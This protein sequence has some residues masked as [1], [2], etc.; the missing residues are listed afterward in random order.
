MRASRRGRV[1][2]Y[3]PWTA[4]LLGLAPLLS[5]MPPGTPTAR[6]PFWRAVAFSSPG[7]LTAIVA[8]MMNT[9][10][11]RFYAARPGMTLGMVGAAF[12]LVRLID[13]P[14]DPVLG[15]LID[16]TRV[17]FGRYRLWLLASIPVLLVSFWALFLPPEKVGTGYLILW[18]L[19][20]NIGGSMVFLSHYPWAASLAPNY[21]ERSR[22]FAMIQVFNVIGSVGILLL[23]ALT[24]GRISAGD[25]ASTATIGIII[26][27]LVPLCL[28]MVAIFT[29]EAA[30]AR[31]RH[32]IRWRE[33]PRLL[34]HPSVARLVGGDF[35]LFFAGAV[36]APIQIFF[37]KEAKSLSI[38]EISVL[39]IFSV[40]AG[41]FGTPAWTRLASRFGKHRALQFAALLHAA[42]HVALVLLP[43]VAPGH[44]LIALAPMAVA[45]FAVGFCTVAYMFL[46]RAMAG[47]VADEVRHDL[48]RERTSLVFSLVTTTS[49]VGGALTVA[50]TFPLLGRLGFR[51][52]EGAINTPA[53]IHGLVLIYLLMPLLFLA[54]GILVLRGYRLDAARHAMVRAE[55]D[56]R[57]QVEWQAAGL[58][59]D[60]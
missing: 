44:G 5:T 42:A 16:R 37:L 22:L 35:C 13:I 38:A 2:R 60:I 6:L 56:C 14:F 51:A 33:L 55:L 26:M 27:I 40:G 45:L 41:L 21:T 8:L 12:A 34:G 25:P 54:A 3:E 19:L 59:A 17:A 43:A 15:A 39:M 1:L 10:M 20:Y 52:A 11:P 50:A 36:T 47:D 53:A 4:E 18:L 57:D 48:G 49:K 46:L 32:T 30:Q 29:P 23:P 28:G 31:V 9:Y 24:Q 7:L 58:Q